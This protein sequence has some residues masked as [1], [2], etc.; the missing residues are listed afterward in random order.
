VLLLHAGGSAIMAVIA[1]LAVGGL[2]WVLEKMVG[3]TAEP[4]RGI[5]N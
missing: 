4:S 3:K 1:S 2:V 5:D